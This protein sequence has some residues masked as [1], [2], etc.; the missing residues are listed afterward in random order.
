MS[1]PGPDTLRQVKDVSRPTATFAIALVPET[2]RAFLGCQDFKVYEVDFAAAKP[3]PKE[4]YAH[5]SYVTGVAAALGGRVVASGGY[6][7]KLAWWDAEDR[8]VV[9][10]ADAHAKWIRKVIASPDG[11]LVASVADDMVCK[12]W[13]AASGR[14]VR[15]LRG[16]AERTP[17]HFPSMLY[18]LCFS[19]DGR[20]LAT[21]DKVG[22]VVVWDAAT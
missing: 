13:D 22:K 2:E 12:L 8:R 3:E 4:L 20:K 19:A 10:T 14:L 17:T 1:T 9:R 6:D 7:G 15:E 18:G 16:H 5:E 21:A 11:T